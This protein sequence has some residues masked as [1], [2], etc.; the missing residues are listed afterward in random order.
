MLPYLLLGMMGIFVVVLVIIAMTYGITILSTKLERKLNT[1]AE[2][3][4]YYLNNG[5]LNS[6]VSIKLV[7]SSMCLLDNVFVWLFVYD[8]YYM[9]NS[10]RAALSVQIVGNG[11][12]AS[13]TAISAGGG[14]GSLFSFSWGA[15][16]DFVGVVE[17]LLNGYTAV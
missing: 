2:S 11:E 10:S 4:A 12:F 7:D 13:V 9:R 15:E 17:N 1:S 6:A 8:K 3:L 14:N 5:I 16:D